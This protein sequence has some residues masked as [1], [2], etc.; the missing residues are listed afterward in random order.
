VLSDNS[1][2]L[3]NWWPDYF[4]V[5]EERA[6]EL[7]F[8]HFAEATSVPIDDFLARTERREVDNLR[9]ALQNL[10]S[11]EVL[12]STDA[13]QL[14]FTAVIVRQWL[15]SHYH[16]AERRLRIPPMREEQPRPPQSVAEAPSRL[17]VGQV[18][19]YIDHENFVRS[20]AR[21]RIA[22][23]RESEPS[24]RWF[25]RSLSQVLGEVEKRFGRIDQKVAVAF[26]DRQDEMR[27]QTSYT[28]RDFAVR[29]P[30]RTGKGNEADFKLADEIRR[31][32]AQ[33]KREG[34]SLRDAIVITG[35]ADF[36]NVISGLKNDG[37]NVHVWAAGAS[38]SQTLLN[39]VGRDNVVML[40]DICAP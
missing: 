24:T 5:A 2:F 34:A 39:L 21:I 9:V 40:D 6:I 10:Q 37:V 30:E 16:A 38:A 7:F 31:S 19:V 20:L 36:T 27:L 33:A 14:R 32:M 1:I 11:C 35:D 26:W 15:R 28:K 29:S 4:G 18:G 23:N 8:H 3:R 22:K 17:L 12:D 25:D 13:G